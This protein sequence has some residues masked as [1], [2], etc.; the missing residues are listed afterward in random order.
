MVYYYSGCDSI[1]QGCG[2]PP[3][4]GFLMTLLLMTLFGICFGFGAGIAYC[5]WLRNKRYDDDYDY[6]LVDGETY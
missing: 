4:G 3:I 5:G 1:Y 2:I 6:D